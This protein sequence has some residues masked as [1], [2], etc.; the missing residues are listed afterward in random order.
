MPVRTKSIYHPASNHDGKRILVTRYWPRGVA[1]DRV[2]EYAPAVAP[3]RD[4]L[5]AFRSGEVGWPEYRLR[6]RSQIKGEAPDQQIDRLAAEARRGTITLMCV[7]RD[8]QRC[9]R[10]LLRRLIERRMASA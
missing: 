3:S 8:D 5:R 2:D 9:H 4:L 7:C 6:Y 1:R 10:T